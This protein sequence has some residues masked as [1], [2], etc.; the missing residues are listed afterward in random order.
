[1]DGVD[2]SSFFSVGNE[3]LSVL[4]ELGD[5]I[6]CW[7]CHQRHKVEYG[8][9][10]LV[11]GSLWPSNTLAFFSCDGKTYLCGIDRKDITSKMIGG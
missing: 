4:P 11:D 1:M 7:M 8:Q 5:E 10:M 9:K 2:I 6:V 3:E